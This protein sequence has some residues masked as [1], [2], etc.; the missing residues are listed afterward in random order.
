M[1]ITCINCC[2]IH[3]MSIESIFVTFHPLGHISQVHLKSTWRMRHNT[4]HVTSQY[5]CM[6][7][8]IQ[9]WP[10]NCKREYTVVHNL[11]LIVKYMSAK[12]KLFQA[13]PICNLVIANPITWLDRCLIDQICWFN[14][15]ETDWTRLLLIK[16]YLLNPYQRR[17]IAIE[18][19]NSGHYLK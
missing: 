19:T 1:Y 16:W 13:M 11:R 17:A 8:N 7:G 3:N 6:G 14:Y 12:N 5:Q 10:L 18:I 4:I 2:H 15:S 9:E